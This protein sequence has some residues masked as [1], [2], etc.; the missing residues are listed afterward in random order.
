VSGFESI[1]CGSTS[2]TGI[3]RMSKSPLGLVNWGV[4]LAIG[5]MRWTHGESFVRVF[6]LADRAVD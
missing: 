4:L 3:P 5:A 2:F 6:R 1:C